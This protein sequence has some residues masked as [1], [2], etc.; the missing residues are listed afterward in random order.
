MILAI[1]YSNDRYK[2]AQRFNSK[3]V[4][5]AGADTVIEYSPLNIDSAFR[6][7]NKDIFQYSRGDGLWIW[8]PYII[9]DA[10]T[11]VSD[12][13]Y[14]VYTDSGSAFVRKIKHLIEAMNAQKTDIM[15]FC[16]NQQECKYTKRDALILMDCDREDILNSLQICGTYIIIRKNEETCSFVN[17]YLQYAQD[18]RIITD[19][20]NVMGKDN[21]P[22]FIE[23]RHDQTVLSL[24]CKKHGIKPFRDPSEWG[25][26][27]SM[28][29]K[30]VLERS[31]YAQIIESHRNPNIYSIF[32]LKYRTW[33]K[34]LSVDYY[35]S[36]FGIKRR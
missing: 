34:Y 4:R 18:R 28:F 16:I 14:V 24:L 27:Y 23:N 11:K 29:P 22:E 6:E 30:D 31:T 19:E 1:N 33:Y 17:E 12:G 5:W 7:K 15:V 21:Y 2:A 10:L 3:R 13:D 25:M 32:Q 35:C 9:R 36:K 26:D 20:P 8:K